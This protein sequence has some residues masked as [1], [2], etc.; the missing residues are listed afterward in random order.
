MAIVARDLCP[1]LCPKWNAVFVKQIRCRHKTTNPHQ[2][3]PVSSKDITEKLIHFR[4]SVR[5]R[6]PISTANQNQ[7]F[8]YQR[9]ATN[10]SMLRSSTPIGRYWLLFR[11][12][13]QCRPCLHANDSSANDP[14]V[15][16]NLIELRSF[17]KFWEVYNEVCGR[18][19]HLVRLSGRSIAS[20]HEG[21]GERAPL[22]HKF[23]KTKNYAALKQHWNKIYLMA[24]GFEP[25]G[26]SNVNLYYLIMVS[27][28]Y[29]Y[30]FLYNSIIP[31]YYS[32]LLFI[33]YSYIVNPV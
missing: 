7:L 28:L 14:A 4:C 20:L 19:S 17:W 31:I 9:L 15:L 10:Q 1:D 16:K 23:S 25:Y 29:I 33:Y 5:Q 2:A 13:V 32:L 26:M 11:I 27:S 18:A 22:S 24:D 6:A 21:Y 8:P 12:R 30:H 3:Q